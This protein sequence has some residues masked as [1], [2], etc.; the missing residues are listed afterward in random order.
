MTPCRWC[1]WSIWRWLGRRS[2]CTRCSRTMSPKALPSVPH[3]GSPC[4]SA[5]VSALPVSLLATLPTSEVYSTICRFKYATRLLLLI[6]HCTTLYAHTASFL[7]EACNSKLYFVQNHT[8]HL[9]YDSYLV[10]AVCTTL[11]NS[12]TFCLKRDK[13]NSRAHFNKMS[14][15]FYHHHLF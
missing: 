1:G 13:D 9:L 10:V 15:F 8:R 7:L 3:A 11:P 2:R 12:S 14:V 6:A 5:S 4:F